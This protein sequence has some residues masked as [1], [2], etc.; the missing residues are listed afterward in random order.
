MTLHLGTLDELLE[1]TSHYLL[2]T[3]NENMLLELYS[4]S[5]PDSVNYYLSIRKLMDQWYSDVSYYT[6]IRSVFV[7]HQ[8]RD[9]LFLSSQ[10]EYYQEKEMIASGLSSHLKTP[11]LQ[12]S[13]KWETVTLGESRCY[14]RCCRTRVAG[15]SWGYW[16]ASILWPSP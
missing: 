14:S 12:A 9:E 13:L 4:D 8:D 6:I 5:G 10:R 16:S 2:R 11:N 1:Q 15:F 3:A 7:Y